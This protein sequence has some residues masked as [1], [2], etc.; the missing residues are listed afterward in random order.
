[1]HDNSNSAKSQKLIETNDSTSNTLSG[2]IQSHGFLVVTTFN[3]E[4]VKFSSGLLKCIHKSADEITGQA[5]STIMCTRHIEILKSFINSSAL[6]HNRTT[7][8]RLYTSNHSNSNHS[9]IFY[10]TLHTKQNYL[11]IELE[12]YNRNIFL[13]SLDFFQL[14]LGFSK[15]L[16]KTAGLTQAYQLLVNTV[17]RISGFSRV[18]LHQFHPNWIGQV[19]A[20]SKVNDIDS[21]LGLYFPGADIPEQARQLYTLNYMR[22]LPDVNATCQIILPDNFDQDNKPL[23]LSFA[24]LRS[25]APTHIKHLKSM[26]VQA[27]MTISIIHHNQLW[28]LITCHNLDVCEFAYPHRS[29]IELITHSFS[30]QLPK[31][32]RQA[33]NID[34]TN[35]KT[36]QTLKSLVKSDIN[37]SNK[38]NQTT[39]EFIEGKIY[40]FI[41]D[42]AAYLLQPL[43]AVGLIITYKNQFFGYGK[44]PEQNKCLQ[45]IAHLKRRYKD[46]I[47]TSFKLN[48]DL[49]SAVGLAK[50]LP[51]I[52]AVPGPA[53]SNIRFIWFRE[54]TK[55][56]VEWAKEPTHA[57]KHV[58]KLE[59][60]P[61]YSQWRELIEN[62]A[63]SWS[64]PDIQYALE[65]SDIFISKIFIAQHPRDIHT[66][67]AFLDMP[68]LGII[69]IDSNQR[70][71]GINSNAA[72][73]LNVDTQDATH[74]AFWDVMPPELAMVIESQSFINDDNQ[75][76]AYTPSNCFVIEC[77]THTILSLPFP[78]MSSNASRYAVCYLMLDVSLFITDTELLEN[79]NQKLMLKAS[80]AESYFN[81]PLRDIYLS[82][83]NL[84]LDHQ[85]SLNSQAHRHL[86]LLKETQ[87]RSKNLA[88]DL[89]CN[90]V[91][92]LEQHEDTENPDE[93]QLENISLHYRDLLKATSHSEQKFDSN[94][95]DELSKLHSALLQ[96]NS[97][98]HWRDI[99]FSFILEQR[100]E[101][102]HMNPQESK[103]CKPPCED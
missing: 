51:G 58:T 45:L 12:P 27:A 89:L 26:N 63:Q 32:L 85:L 55:Y 101:F 90:L 94:I 79:F 18:N 31:L 44:T 60:S 80:Q 81:Q 88:I 95:S 73:N 69:V 15:S 67:E 17:R 75:Q 46:S 93:A 16:N 82:L 35:H 49:H 61:N 87:K 13:Q 9:K 20:E 48:D 11:F 2:L 5:L 65:I 68:E 59:Q 92:L 47:V 97:F 37:N 54:E 29:L 30:A 74:K 77:N 86:N 36:V 84:H 25:L 99:I 1:M 91:E 102:T 8:T 6:N 70:L 57:I 71:L 72:I 7:S 23:D 33:E 98:F 22:N 19:V 96:S 38:K 78:L 39:A 42:Y 24:E 34:E 40:S 56:T 43:Q 83:Q 4:I 50:N 76:M 28:G 100:D 103:P 66:I 53:D 41:R 62:Q 3:L 14:A 21:Y 64:R 10:A 52:L